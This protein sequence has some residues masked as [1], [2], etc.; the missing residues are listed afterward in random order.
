M[1]SGCIELTKMFIELTMIYSK[2]TCT[3]NNLYWNYWTPCI[4]V[5]LMLMLSPIKIMPEEFENTTLLKQS[6]SKCFSNLRNFKML[7]FRFYLTGKHFENWAFWKRW[8]TMCNNNHIIYLPS[9]F[10]RHK[11]KMASGCWCFQ[12]PVQCGQDTFDAFS[13]W[14]QTFQIPP[15]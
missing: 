11:S 10:V 1:T 12:I 4:V 9:F 13:E 15:V 5:N 3:K 14:K 8:P 6:F 7:A 2:W